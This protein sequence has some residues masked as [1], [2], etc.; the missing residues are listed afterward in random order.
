MEFTGCL[1]G[2]A[3]VKMRFQI[4]QTVSTK[5]I[6]LLASTGAEAGLD[7]P[8]T[9]NAADMV[10]LNL[11]TATYVTAQQTDGT[12]PERTVECIINPDAIF[13]ALL[14]GGSTS[15][16][17]L[18]ATTVTTAST[19]GLTVTD[20]FDY[21]STSMDSGS[22]WG[23]AG[24]NAGRI[25]KITAVSTTAATVTVAFDS[26]IAVGDQFLH[27]P[28][29]PMEIDSGAAVTL[30]STF[31]QIDATAAVATATNAADFIVI[32]IYAYDLSNSGTTRSAVRL[33]SSDHF[34]NKL[35]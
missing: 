35:S 24:A 15:S 9:T 16:T 25:R 23:Y 26:D 29:F 8:S 30:T 20:G 31:E 3:P 7:A 17:A 32:Q 13:R 28:F 10:G 18:S 12:S 6:P 5:G 2:G 27:A 1:S 14:S 34:L 33:V 11:D 4:A 21:S 22:V 19:D